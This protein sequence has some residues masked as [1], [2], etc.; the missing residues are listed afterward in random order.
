MLRYRLMLLLITG[1]VFHQLLAF[2]VLNYTYLVVARP[3]KIPF[4]YV[5][6]CLDRRKRKCLSSEGEHSA[7]R[8]IT[9]I[10]YI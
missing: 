7:S 1:L 4:T 8:N 3:S 6:S 2:P 10:L 9:Y 5:Q